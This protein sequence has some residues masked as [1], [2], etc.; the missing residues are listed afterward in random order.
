MPQVT[1]HIRDSPGLTPSSLDGGLVF[2]S[3]HLSQGPADTSAW[4]F[5]HSHPSQ[6]EAVSVW[7]EAGPGHPYMS[8]L[9]VQ[10]MRPN[11]PLRR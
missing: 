6:E 8:L 5:R 2:S 7:G 4:A 11:H 3:W 1:Q 10:T 9:S